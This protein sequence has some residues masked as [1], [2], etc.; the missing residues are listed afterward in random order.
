MNEGSVKHINTHPRIYQY[1]LLIHAIAHLQ[2]NATIQQVSLKREVIQVS[3][4]SFTMLEQGRDN[5][6]FVRLSNFGVN[7]ARDIEYAITELKAQGA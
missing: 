7:A 6:G 5:I 2:K 4:V 1:I 3:P